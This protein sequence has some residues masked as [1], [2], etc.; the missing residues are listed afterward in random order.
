MTNDLFFL[1]DGLKLT[2]LIAIAT[3][4]ISL[5]VGTLFALIKN[6]LPGPLA[7]IV[8]AY[9]ELF[10]CTPNILWI[11]VIYLM[12]PGDS[13]MKGIFAFCL[14]TTAVVAEIVRGGL[15]SI[16]KGQFEAAHS[17]GFHYLQTLLYIVLPQTFRHIVPSLLS[18]II[19]IVKDTSFLYAAVAVQEF[20]GKAKILAG[21]ATDTTTIFLIYASIALVYFLLNFTLSVLV[22]SMQKK[23]AH[24]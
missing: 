13:T 11:L 21:K 5:A 12:F 9:I 22:R 3:I 1:L 15:N 20:T 8:S 7:W 19:T 10:R 14:F 17:Q 2:F 23:Q 6:Y 16:P 4:I 18:Q 24:S